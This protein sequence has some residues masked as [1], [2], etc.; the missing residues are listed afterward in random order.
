MGLLARLR[1]RRSAG[2]EG[3][4]IS[5]QGGLRYL[6]LGTDTV[7]SAMRLTEPEELVLSYTRSMLAFLLFLPDPRR[8][9]NIGLGGGSLAKWIYRNL[10]RAQQVVLELNPRVIAC[11]RQ[12]FHLP[13]D[14]RR[15]RVVEADGAQWV[16]GHADCTDVVLVDGYDGKSQAV[17]LATSG[18][19]T[20][21][22]HC[23]HDQ[24]VLVVN[25]WGNDRRFD[26]YLKRI[27]GAFEG[28][29]CCIPAA[30]RGN[31]IVLAF[32]SQPSATR[33]DQLREQAHLLEERFSVEF[34]EFVE[35][36]KRLNPHTSRRLII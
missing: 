15:L 28:Q 11:A 29:V 25:L 27:E 30:Q 19:Y 20:A 10:P 24:G 22:A 14:G 34:P 23:L 17:E 7:Q 21:A 9:V 12:Y 1:G 33:W 32:K 13:P 8:V 6:H 26:D 3:V 31:I 35:A 18:F 4:E 2:G 36:M 16:A 5:E